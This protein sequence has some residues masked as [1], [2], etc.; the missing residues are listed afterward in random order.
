MV[1][2]CPKP[3]PYNIVVEKVKAFLR[4]AS[5]MKLGFVMF[6]VYAIFSTLL[7]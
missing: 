2:M 3:S 4:L 6:G 7:N 5:N 1:S